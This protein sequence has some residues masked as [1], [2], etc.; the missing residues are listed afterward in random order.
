M[1]QRMRRLWWLGLA[2]AS[3]LMLHGCSSGFSWSDY[4]IDGNTD[5]EAAPLAGRYTGSL[6][7]WGS[8]ATYW[9]RL[10]TDSQVQGVA[11][12]GGSTVDLTG[13]VT[14]IRH[15]KLQGNGIIIEGQFSGAQHP[16][17]P[18]YYEWRGVELRAT[19]RRAEGETPDPTHTAIAYHEA[20][21][22]ALHNNHH[23][24]DWYDN[25]YDDHSDDWWSN[26]SGSGGGTSSG[27]SDSG[28]GGGSTDSGSSGA[29]AGAGSG[30]GGGSGTDSG[31]VD[32]SGDTTDGGI[33][34]RGP[35]G[36]R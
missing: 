5:R 14:D 11:T 12:L 16:Q 1:D 28:S 32:G 18:S 34:W 10:V 13:V 24:S 9:F 33:I 19:W 17:E 3:A 35:K 23:D 22:P 36:R 30:S 26:G 15:L 31:P 27:G 29:G 2:V 8:T 6:R 4:D 25:W 20:W 7:Q 21:P